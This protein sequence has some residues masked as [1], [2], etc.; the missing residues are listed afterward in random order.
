M[1]VLGCTDPEAT[2]FNPE[3]EIDDGSCQYPPIGGC[4]DPEAI[5]FN[6]EAEVDDGSCQYTPVEGCM[7]DFADNYNPEADTP[8]ICTVNIPICLDSE[9]NNAYIGDELVNVIESNEL[10]DE[11]QIQLQQWGN[12]L[13]NEQELAFTQYLNDNTT[14][15]LQFQFIEDNSLCTYPEVIEGCTDPASPNYNPEATVDDGSCVYE[16]C[17]GESDCPYDANGDGEIGSAD[18]LEFLVAYGQPCSNL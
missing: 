5:N 14:N 18:L 16:E 11:A 12:S 8:T 6:P 2:N 17:T 4:T 15:A 10:P 7:L 13:T 3:A 1:P 9:A